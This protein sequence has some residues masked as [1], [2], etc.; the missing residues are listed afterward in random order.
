MRDIYLI[1]S[2]LEMQSAERGAAANTLSSYGSDLEQLSVSLTGKQI[3]LRNC[4]TSHIRAH[5]G[6]IAKNGASASTQ[7]RHLSTIKQFFKFLYAENIRTDNPAG[8]IEPPRKSRSLP[9][10]LSI[11]EVG[12]MLDMVQNEAGNNTVSYARQYRAVRLH[13]LL[14]LLYA[15]GLRVSELVSLPASAAFTRSRFLNVKGKGTK[16]RLV[17]LSEKSTIAM[18]NFVKFVQTNDKKNNRETIHFT[19]WLFPASSTS[20]H[21]TRQA[22]ARD[23]KSLASRAK[24]PAAR[25]SPHVLRHAFASHLLQNGADLRSVQ[26]MLGH[27]DISTTQIYTHVLEDRLRQ[28]VEDHHPLAG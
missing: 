14:E 12:L 20:G 15:T 24:I 21:L 8:P 13:V 18:L 1:E 27:S 19:N 2:F 22:F 10:I 4:D 3:E 11:H 23:L 6:A 9:K 16:E 26:I 5:L 25:V 7:T 17:P 28:L